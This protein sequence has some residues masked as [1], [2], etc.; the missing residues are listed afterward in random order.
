MRAAPLALLVLALG[1][2]SAALSQNGDRFDLDCHGT[3]RNKGESH[4]EPYAVRIHID[5]IAKKF[6]FDAC[7][8]Y[9]YPIAGV[10][11]GMIVYTYDVDKE[12]PDHRAGI[13]RSDEGDYYWPQFDTVIIW[14]NEGKFR[15][16]FVYDEGEPA[17][18]RHHTM[19]NQTCVRAPFGGSPDG[20]LPQ[21][22]TRLSQ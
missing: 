12:G 9:V 18:V 17:S 16:E 21:Y 5:L 14:L 15:R 22:L 20:T 3:V 13:Y 7:G 4:L 19:T 10:S 2:P 6:C 8:D 1:L 11:G